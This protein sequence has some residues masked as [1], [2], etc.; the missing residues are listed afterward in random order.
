MKK[1]TNIDVHKV[2]MPIMLMML[3]GYY[4]LYL[5]VFSNKSNVCYMGKKS[6]GADEYIFKLLSDGYAKD[7]LNLYYMS[8]KTRSCVT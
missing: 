8:Q 5:E 1:T 2:K 3:Y 7:K 6:D 4:S